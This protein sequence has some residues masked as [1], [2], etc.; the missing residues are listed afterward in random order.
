M[1]ILLLSLFCS[2]WMNVCTVFIAVSVV[3]WCTIMLV[4]F[5]HIF[6]HLLAVGWSSTSAAFVTCAHPFSLPVCVSVCGKH[7]NVIFKSWTLEAS[8]YILKI[9]PSLSFFPKYVQQHSNSSSIHHK[10]SCINIPKKMH[11]NHICFFYFTLNLFEWWNTRTDFLLNPTIGAIHVYA[12][13]V[14]SLLVHLPEVY[15][16]YVFVWFL[17]CI[18]CTLY[19]ICFVCA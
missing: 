17:D 15:V 6:T 2:T 12:L 11:G 10:F 5:H 7:G 1:T 4:L 8:K 13:S 9:S 16:Y 3:C 19:T 14:H 18:R